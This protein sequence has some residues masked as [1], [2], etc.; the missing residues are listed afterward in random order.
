[1]MSLLSPPNTQ[2][3]EYI[4]ILKRKANTSLKYEQPKF[5]LNPTREKSLLAFPKFLVLHTKLMSH[6]S[7]VR[8]PIYIFTL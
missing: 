2:P 7:T 3:L 4:G 8:L 1:M 5:P 6:A